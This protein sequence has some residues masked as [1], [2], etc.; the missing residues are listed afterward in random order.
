[1]AFVACTRGEGSGESGETATTW[2]EN[3]DTHESTTTPTDTQ[4]RIAPEIAGQR[5]LSDARRRSVTRGETLPEPAP[6]VRFAVI[7]DFGTGDDPA[8]EVAA[9]VASWNVDFVVTVGDNNYPAGS[10]D[11]IDKNVGRDWHS[12]IYPYTGTYGEGATTNRFWPCPGN[13][14]YSYDTEF[15][16]YTDYFELPGNERYYEVVIGPVHLLCVNSDANEPDSF[17][18]DGVQAGW[19]ESALAAS[20]SPWRFVYQHHPPFSS[21]VY[22][23][24][25]NRQWPFGEWGANLVLSGHEHDYE[26]VVVDDLTHVITGTGGTSTRSAGTFLEGSQT[27]WTDRHGAVLIELS[28]EW[29]RFASID[30]LGALGD[31]WYDAPGVDRKTAVL[32]FPRESTWHYLAGPTETPAGWTAHDY[33]DAEWNTG[34]APVGFGDGVG[35][36]LENASAVQTIYMRTSFAMNRADRV[37]Y[38]LLRIRRDDGAV[39]YLNGQEIYRVGLVEG[40][41]PSAGT[42]AAFTVQSGWEDVYAE[43]L[44]WPT[45]LQ[46]GRNQ[47]ALEVHRAGGDDSDI[48]GD[49]ELLVIPR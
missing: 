37:S 31:L 40:E 41:V 10:S 46:E 20:K 22:G 23:P 24:D 39:L 14:D 11:T 6:T 29:G 30:T 8:A 7:G 36:Q 45:Q 18:S 4:E 43:T 5:L 48:F 38:L 9:L 42:P 13:H 44:L 34:V 17:S 25:P 2:W 1:M 16:P 3:T 19:L 27:F 35:T 49:I 47:L 15:Q 28:S 32:V 12:Y 21:G 26:R 33:D